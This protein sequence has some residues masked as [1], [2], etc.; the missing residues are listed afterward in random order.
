MYALTSAKV[1]PN[2]NTGDG[3]GNDEVG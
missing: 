3:A 2:A 1:G